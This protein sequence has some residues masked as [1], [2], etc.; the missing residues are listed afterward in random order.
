MRVR[1]HS[2]ES[3]LRKLLSIH[4]QSDT[5]DDKCFFTGTLSLRYPPSFFG[6]R[7]LTWRR[8]FINEY[9]TLIFSYLDTIGTV[10]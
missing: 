3:Y 2:T 7:D 1:P 5:D 6:D 10:N 4:S 9:I 8:V